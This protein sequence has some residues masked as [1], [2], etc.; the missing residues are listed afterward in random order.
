MKSVEYFYFVFSIWEWLSIITFLVLTVS[1]VLFISKIHLHFEP[2]Y[3]DADEFYA[4]RV[5]RA[6]GTMHVTSF[7]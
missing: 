6:K 4:I 1:T 3:A 7:I 5:A 2:E